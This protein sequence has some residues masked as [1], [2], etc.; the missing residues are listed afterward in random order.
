MIAYEAR[1][2]VASLDE[3]LRAMEERLIRTQQPPF[4]NFVPEQILC[5]QPAAVE[6]NGITCLTSRSVI[7]PSKD[8]KYGV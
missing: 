1:A 3:R 6:R 8:D 4:I 2:V 7:T 5:D